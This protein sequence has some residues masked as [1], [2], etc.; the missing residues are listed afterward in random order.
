MAEPMEGNGKTQSIPTPEDTNEWQEPALKRKGLRSRVEALDRSLKARGEVRPQP[1]ELPAQTAPR[2]H[3]QELKEQAVLAFE[4]GLLPRSV[5][6]RAKAITIALMGREFGLSPMQSLCGIYVVNGMA[7]LRGSLMLRLIYERV[8]G[9]MITV[10][11]PPD[12]A[13]EE[14]EVEM[15]RP[16]GK[17]HLFR[18]TLEDARK[19]GFM[20]KPIWQQHTS[21]MLRWAAIRTGARIVFA[22]ALAGAYMEDELPAELPHEKASTAP[23]SP[24]VA[25][26]AIRSSASPSN[27]VEIEEKE[28]APS[29]TVPS[30]VEVRSLPMFKPVTEKQINR[31]YAIANGK[32]WSRQEVASYMEKWFKKQ[33]P[34]DLSRVEYDRLCNHLLSSAGKTDKSQPVG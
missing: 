29:V 17:P 6:T 27:A 26:A 13:D 30:R 8:S 19:A 23:E 9:A 15:K 12:K 2:S 18:F 21:T 28:T 16:G 31:L 7:A 3:W 32:S 4:S 33:D 11:T 1:V 25:M 10:L 22:D 14:C 5:D 34:K 24:D 20:N